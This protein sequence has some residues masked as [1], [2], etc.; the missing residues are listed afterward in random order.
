MFQAQD[1]YFRSEK[2]IVVNLSYNNINEIRLFDNESD[3]SHF[4][5]FTNNF[6]PNTQILLN[7]N[8]IKCLCTACNFLQSYQDKVTGKVTLL[9][10]TDHPDLQS[11]I[12]EY[13]P[14]EYFNCLYR[15]GYSPNCPQ[16]CNCLIRPYDKALIVNCQHKNLT[17]FPEALPDI[18]F[19]TFTELNLFGNG[20]KSVKCPLG[21]GY[22]KVTAYNL[23]DNLIREI[24]LTAFSPKLQVR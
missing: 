7:G 3:I 24:N 16:Q 14:M 5:D 15:K 21:P 11:S 1:F 19:S 23:S 12:T 18:V 8:P 20:V 6:V 9:T 10:R 13:I 2:D 4:P 22:Y 17:S